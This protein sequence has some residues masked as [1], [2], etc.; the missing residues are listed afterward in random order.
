MALI[1]VFMP[2]ALEILHRIE[3]CRRKSVLYSNRQTVITVAES[4]PT[5]SIRH[6]RELPRSSQLIDPIK[7]AR[8]KTG[9][10]N[11]LFKNNYYDISL[12]NRR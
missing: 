5:A 8:V 2:G 6:L 1:T 10:T 12:H 9:A 7:N 3:A 11:D 4:E